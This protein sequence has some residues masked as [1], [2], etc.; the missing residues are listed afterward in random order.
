M[1]LQLF[2]AS[3]AIT[4]LILLAHLVNSESFNA[5]L[6][7]QSLGTAYE[8]K[9]HLDAGKEDCYYQNIETGASLYVAFHVRHWIES[10]G[11]QLKLITTIICRFFEV[12]TPMPAFTS[13]AQ[14]A[15]R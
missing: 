6:N 4:A 10:I 2:T 7:S 1:K 13:T 12:A 15:R 5:E 14:L 9:I 11:R 3:S 8:F